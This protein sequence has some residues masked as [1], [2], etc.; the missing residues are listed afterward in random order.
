V[1]ER[2]ELRPAD[3]TQIDALG[4]ALGLSPLVARILVAR[5]IA[6]PEAARR[7]LDLD[8]GGLLPPDQL[9]DLGAACA[10][11]G[12]AIAREEPITIFGD[13]DVDGAT[14][15]A[16][17]VHFLRLVGAHVDY[18]LPDRLREGYGLTVAGI[19][20]VAARGA[21]LL[22]TADCGTNS[23]QEI[24]RARDL[25]MEVIVLDHHETPG[26]ASPAVALVNPH[27]PDSA[28]PDRGLCSAGLAFY[29]VAGLRRWL[30][31][32]AHFGAR[33]E[34]NLKAY[35][36]LVALG[37][38]ADVVQL[39]GLNRL[40]VHHGLAALAETRRPG[41]SSLKALAGIGPGPVSAGQVAFRIAPRLN[42]AGRLGD[43]R[44]AVDLLLAEDPG[45][46]R[47]LAEELDRENA[48][49]QSVEKTVLEEALAQAL[50][51]PEHAAASAVVVAGE[52]WHPGVI[53]IVAARLVERFGRPAVVIA[54][55][56]ARGKG[57]ARSVGEVNLYQ[58]LT[59]CAEHLSGYGGHAAA[60]GLS[61]A[62]HA[63]APFR[64]RFREVVGAIPGERRAARRFLD[65]EV[66]LG[67]LSP[68]L[69][70][71]IG[72]LQPFGAGNPEP[73]LRS[74]EAEVREARVVGGNHLRLRLVGTE[75]AAIGFGMA[76]E[77]PALGSRVDLCYNLRVSEWQGQRRAE[78]H[79]KDLAPSRGA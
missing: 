36:D 30:R 54:L 27:R 13:Y 5:G 40:L 41:L 69:G 14:A 49:R 17:L 11:L 76:D 62:A 4:A 10:R 34:P 33:P 67:A 58:A 29:V 61:L 44:R 77:I 56:G 25:G 39:V 53:G 74:R 23:H 65:A 59:E 21:R 31:E 55:D 51:D 73:V 6:E 3:P 19:E 42:A 71:E 48:R 64:H 22:V 1:K 28:F 35:L 7:F 24:A 26:G 12:E 15:T 50:A 9:P 8:L 45:T 18:Y 47:T 52:G 37:T 20:A 46:A 68:A 75:A 43:A 57:S 78:I 2:W 60:A 66:P 70:E 38:I 79:L 72:R 63:V 32:R 16:I